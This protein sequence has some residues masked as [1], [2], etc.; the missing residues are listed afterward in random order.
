[1]GD[2]CCECFASRC[3]RGV[4]L[5]AAALA[6]ATLSACGGRDGP[7][8]GIVL[9]EVAQ[10]QR[11]SEAT[12]LLPEVPARTGGWYATRSMVPPGGGVAVFDASGVFLRELRA[13]GRGPGEFNRLQD[14]GFGPGDSLWV[15]ESVRAHLFSPP[16]ALEFVRTVQFALP[17]GGRVSRFGFLTRAMYGSSEGMVPPSLRGWDGTV[18]AR[19]GPSGVVEDIDAAMGRL[20]LVDP[21]RAWQADG[22]SYVLSLLDSGGAVLRRHERNLEWFPPNEPY[23]GSFNAVRPPARIADLT[24]GTDGRLWV[25]IRRAHPDWKATAPLG[26]PTTAPRNANPLPSATSFNNLFEVVLE[27][28]DPTSGEVLASRV[29]PGSYRGFVDAQHIAEVVED[30]DGH[31]II[32]IWKLELSD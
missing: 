28:L 30:D 31:I 11:P 1:M 20:A 19:F 4:R 25:L 16:P 26:G 17:T 9:E 29:L 14:V 15:V 3:G 7:A 13:Q 27:V 22:K 24:V 8:P 32:R 6:L 18:R 12:D 5:V 2:R 21:S 23:R 10:L